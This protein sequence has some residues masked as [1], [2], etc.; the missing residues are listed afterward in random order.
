MASTI[1]GSS[2]T[3]RMRAI[4]TASVDHRQ[5]QRETAAP[6]RRAVDMNAAA[7][8]FNCRLDDGQAKPRAFRIL[9]FGS[10]PAIKLIEDARQFVAIN[11]NA[12]IANLDADVILSCTNLDGDARA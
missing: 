12:L 3:I 6:P 9:S 7:V 4:M 1:D 11:A 5:P 8:S 2:S 10:P